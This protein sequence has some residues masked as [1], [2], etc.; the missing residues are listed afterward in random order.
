MAGRSDAEA[1]VLTGVYGAGKT[2]VLEEIAHILE[3][4]GVRFGAIDLD[5]L[6]WF[7]PGHGGHRAGLPVKL[8][9]VDA[10]TGNYY[11][12]GIRRFALAGAL[13][14]PSDADDIRTTLAMPLTVVRL[15]APVEEIE[16]RLSASVPAGRQ[17]DLEVAKRWL[18]EGRG[19][20]VAG[21]VIE[22]TGPIREVALHVL[23]ILD[24]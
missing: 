23:S 2:S 16:R 8:K 11:D 24:W 6:G 22:N 14:F 3:G 18:T 20:A 10:V 9:N 17:D 19:E 4:R 7:D 21:A 13:E 12:A 5:W 1:V 15:I